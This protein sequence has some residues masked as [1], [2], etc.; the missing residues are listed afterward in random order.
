[1]SAIITP[2][3]QQQTGVGIFAVDNPISNLI[4]CH[5]RFMLTPL[6]TDQDENTPDGIVDLNYSLV[7]NETLKPFFASERIARALGGEDSVIRWVETNVHCCQAKDNSQCTN[8]LTTTYRNGSAVRLCWHHD[9]EFLMKGYRHV[10]DA[11]ERNRANW[12]MTWA[13][14]EMRLPKDRDISLIE[15]TF[16]A[17][18]RGFKDELPE[19]AGRI[20]LCQPEEE[21]PTGV[22]K[23]SD[24]T[25]GYSI[26]ELVDQIEHEVA[27]I[28]VDD[29]SGL[30]YMNRP[31][32]QLGKSPAYLCFVTSRPCIGCQ[33]KVNRPF[34][35]R[36]RGL[37]EHDRWSV[38]LCDKCAQEAS[39]DVREWE[40]KRGLRLYVVANQL[41]DFAIERG[42]IKFSN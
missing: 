4:R 25:W 38:P 8:R 16:W 22:T 13:S 26:R 33:G 21:I 34:L 29:E 15:L 24:I 1:M 18:R 35:Y 19:E 28:E 39:Q 5:K 3:I 40:R 30:L 6:P 2:Y 20:A 10:Q 14:S 9:N 31:K 12:I 7:A 11:L 36:A 42:V 37:N 27:T 17:L 41:F 23:E 32:V